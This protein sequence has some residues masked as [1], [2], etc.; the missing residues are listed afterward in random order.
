MT[1]AASSGGAKSQ[2]DGSVPEQDDFRLIFA[3]GFDF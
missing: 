3:L 2:P 1:N